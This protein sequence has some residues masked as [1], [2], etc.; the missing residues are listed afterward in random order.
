MFLLHFFSALVVLLRAS[1]HTKAL[2]KAFLFVNSKGQLSKYGTLGLSRTALLIIACLLWFL[3]G[4]ELCFHRIYCV[5]VWLKDH[6]VGSNTV[7]NSMRITCSL[8]INLLSTNNKLYHDYQ[9][10]WEQ[11]KVTPMKF[12]WYK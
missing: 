9:K 1:S 3:T 5:H 7:D 2:F 4:P 6:T 12:Y 8:A 10:I 11:I